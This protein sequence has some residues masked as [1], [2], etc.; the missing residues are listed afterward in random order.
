MSM[1][2]P[3]T[4]AGAITFQ[5]AGSTQV[6]HWAASEASISA[7]AGAPAARSDP[8]VTPLIAAQTSANFLKEF[9]KVVDLFQV[10]KR[11]HVA[12][13][14]IQ[15]V[16]QRG[17]EL[18]ELVGVFEVLGVLDLQDFILL[19]FAVGE[20]DVA[21]GLP[22]RG[23]RAL[24]THASTTSSLP[25]TGGR[26]QQDRGAATHTV[27]HGRTWEYDKPATSRELQAAR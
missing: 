10:G 8:L 25:Q 20:P 22:I 5:P 19:R 2:A 3:A 18:H 12:V 13:V 24:R 15:V 14:L 17:G 26:E 6:F 4:G 11:E 16:A 21:I 1:L 27:F 9:L 7:T 23:H